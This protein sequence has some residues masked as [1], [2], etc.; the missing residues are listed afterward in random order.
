MTALAPTPRPRCT[1]DG[2]E[3]V[4]TGGQ[5]VALDDLR[6]RLHDLTDAAA[7]AARAGFATQA[8]LYRSDADH[9]RS[10]LQE[11]DTMTPTTMHCALTAFLTRTDRLGPDELHD[12]FMGEVMEQG[13][14][15]LGPGETDALR[16]TSHLVEISLHGITGRGTSEAQAID[17]W[18]DAARRM[19]TTEI[20]TE[21]A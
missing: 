16:N 8:A 11:A 4:W 5:W 10:I 7:C 20:T 1:I 18:R 17:D 2:R 9:I 19:I 13:G 15:W 14:T 21:E 6:A 3:S 12:A